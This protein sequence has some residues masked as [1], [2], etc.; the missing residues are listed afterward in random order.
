MNALHNP[1]SAVAAAALSTN[2]LV[3]PAPLKLCDVDGS[4]NL[5]TDA[6]F[7]APPVTALFPAPRLRQKVTFFMACNCRYALRYGEGYATTKK[8]AI[9][10]WLTPRHASLTWWGMCRTGMFTAPLRYGMRTTLRLISFALQIEAMHQR[11]APMPHYYLFIAG[12]APGQ[13]GKGVN[14]VLLRPMLARMDNENMPAYLE[15]QSA[16]NVAL[17]E[18]LGFRV[19][20]NKPLKGF[21]DFQNWGMLRLPNQGANE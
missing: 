11:V 10:L 8:D 7:D 18:Q 21:A 13:Q 17:Y 14:A 4:A 20:E 16:D 19:I 1:E 6:F 12:V 3:I 15:T 9:A 5:L 2:Y